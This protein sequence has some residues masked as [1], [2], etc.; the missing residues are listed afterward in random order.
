MKKYLLGIFAI[1]VAISLSAFSVDKNVKV[2]KTNRVL[3][4]YGQWY[5]T[6]DDGNK[7]GTRFYNSTPISKTTA[8]PLSGCPD[9]EVPVCAV[10]SNTTLTFGANIPGSEGNDD[11]YIFDAQ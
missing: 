9:E 10:G 2:K 6:I 5:H 4:F 8:T 7:V 3:N 1:I 11:N